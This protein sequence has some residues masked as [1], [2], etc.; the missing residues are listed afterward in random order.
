MQQ[1]S[2]DIRY[3]KWRKISTNDVKYFFFFKLER[4]W[5]D[6]GSYNGTINSYK[7]YMYQHLH[8]M[9]LQEAISGKLINSKTG[10]LPK[11]QYIFTA[12]H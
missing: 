2:N 8:R 6:D 11:S 1:L 10:E 4:L 3:T 7:I 9:M 5:K 12:K